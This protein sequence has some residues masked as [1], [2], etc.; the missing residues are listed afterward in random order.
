MDTKK[1]VEAL[2]SR[3]FEAVYVETAAEAVEKALSY[4]PEGASVSW[5][6][7]MTIVDSGL[8]SKIRSGNYRLFDRDTA[9]DGD[10]RIELMRQGLLADYFLCSFNA[11]TEDGTAVN[12][13]GFGNRVAAI[14]FGPK[15]VIALVGKNKIVSDTEKALER[16]K[17]VA[18]PKNAVR[19][20]KKPEEAPSLCNITQ[21]LTAGGKGRIKVIV[22][23]EDA[24]Y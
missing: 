17:T 10:E 14:T 7:S 12:I 8:L 1:T 16:A 20:G 13:D 23:G 24:G 21:I 6:G 4:I 19:F 18:A 5:G 11:V 2:N 15:N 3:G 9:K 22:F